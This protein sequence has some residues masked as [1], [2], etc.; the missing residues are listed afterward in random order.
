MRSMLK[1]RR[2]SPAMIVA[3]I[4]L[5][6]ALGG[7]VYAANKISGKTIKK[8]SEPG[9]RLK[10]DSVT[11]K[12]VKESTLKI[13]AGAVTGVNSG[14]FFLSSVTTLNF[15]TVN[16]SDCSGSATAGS[17]SLS[18]PALG[19]QATDHV[20]VTPPPGWE[21]TFVLTA[22][23]KPAS[24]TVTLAACNNYF[25]GAGDPDGGGGPYKL[26]VIR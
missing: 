19:I 5:F 10:K 3:L 14:D 23:P 24:S 16:A 18:I 6:V 15:G 7:S 22:I 9:N 4:A 12:Q 21:P 17:P 26:L 11:G 2:P 13:P 20:L 25:T 1:G 8:G